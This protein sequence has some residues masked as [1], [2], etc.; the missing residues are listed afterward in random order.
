MDSLRM[1]A[2]LLII[3]GALG[4]AYGSFSYTEETHQ[5]NIGALHLSVDEK[6]YVNIP[7]WAGVG[8]ILAGEILLVVG[9]RRS[10]RI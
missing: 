8:A 4:L 2:T 6:Q 5:A 10:N 7:V 9:R 1:L 3:A